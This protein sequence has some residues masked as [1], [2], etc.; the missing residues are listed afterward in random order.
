[1]Q[2][3]YLAEPTRQTWE[4]AA[5]GFLEKWKFPNCVG[6]ID[7]KHVTI[8][9]PQRSGSMYFSYLKKFSIVL[10][11]IVG[12]DYKF[13]CIDVGGYGKN[14]DSGIFDESVMGRKFEN[15]QFALPAAKS[16]PNQT[17]T[18][19][20]VLIGDEGFPLK[21]YLMRPFP[22]R[23][24]RYNPEKETFNTRLSTARRVVENAFGILSQKWRIFFRPL[25][26]NVETTIKIVQAAC[27]LHN[28]LRSKIY[29]DHYFTVLEPPEPQMKAFSNFNK[30]AKRSRNE[31]FEIRQNF[32]NYFNIEK[33]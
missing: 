4:V 7:G 13:I 25:E 9:C 12:P 1:M 2:S 15:E 23:V 3:T 32:V 6:S 10:L 22:Y 27:V 11:A 8:K 20:Y 21:T 28:F 33:E 14:S 17:A 24:S 19:P 18:T 5:N 29:E 31:V 30:D 16:L 26:T